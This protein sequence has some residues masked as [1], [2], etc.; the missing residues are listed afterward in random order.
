MIQ[1]NPVMRICISCKKTYDRKNLLK[2][3]KDYKQGISFNK[4][5]GRS[6]YICQEKKCY[7][8]SKIKKKLQKALRTFLEPEFIEILEKEITS[9][10]DF[11]NKGI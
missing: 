7:S 1:Q 9:Y 2:I 5:M 4:G 8:D 6:A 3:T 11:S 10:N